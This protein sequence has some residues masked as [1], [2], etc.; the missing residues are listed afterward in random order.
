MVGV[1]VRANHAM[2]RLALH[3][4]VEKRFP[5][6]FGRIEVQAGVD[7]RPAVP[8]LEQPQVNV[9]ERAGHGETNPP[10]PGRYLKGVI[11]R[12]LQPPPGIGQSSVLLIDALQSHRS[13]LI[14]PAVCASA[15]ALS[16][17]LSLWGY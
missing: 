12:V 16:S 5:M 8:I 2:H 4:P 3:E 1:H 9:V 17:K 6:R 7:N 13:S 11:A 10:D 14:E 15:H